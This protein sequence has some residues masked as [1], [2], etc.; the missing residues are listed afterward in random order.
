MKKRYILLILIAFFAL[1]F[2]VFMKDAAAPTVSDNNQ[3]VLTPE[4][5]PAQKDDLIIVEAPLPGA[6]VSSPLLIKGKARGNWYF[7]A[8]FPVTLTDW[9][10]NVLV[11]SYATAQGEWMT[12]EYVPFTATL[13][14]SLP[15]NVTNR[16]GFLILKKDNPSG[17]PQ[18]DNSL[19]IKVQL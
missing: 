4:P 16:T 6:K 13:N 3:P 12:T 15:A 14:Y 2:W 8:T 18:F 1:L 17:E 19:E 5:K 9:E 11:E 10:G 7:E